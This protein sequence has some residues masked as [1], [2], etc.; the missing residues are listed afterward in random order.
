MAKAEVVKWDGE[1]RILAKSLIP[2]VDN[3]E[4]WEYPSTDYIWD[5]EKFV[6]DPEFKPLEQ[7]LKVFGVANKGGEF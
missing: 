7:D 6:R 1:D 2:L 4:S 5:G 3:N